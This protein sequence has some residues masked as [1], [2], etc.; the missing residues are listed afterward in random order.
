MKANKIYRLSL[1][2]A[3]LI[4]LL[5]QDINATA[6][7]EPYKRSDGKTVIAPQFVHLR[8]IDPR[9]WSSF[10]EKADAT[11]L[12]VKFHAAR[13]DHECSL[14]WRQQD[15]KQSWRVRVNGKLIGE[16]VR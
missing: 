3:V 5:L 2:I 8:N 14:F 6:E 7:A 4:S 12:E 10:P 16:L 1:L 15:V 9:E 11:Q 13:N